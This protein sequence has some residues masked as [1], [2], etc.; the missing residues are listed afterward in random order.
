MTEQS[1]PQQ[2]VEQLLRKAQNLM[3]L[4][5]LPHI[6][7][8]YLCLPWY[9]KR[10]LN[11]REET[12][13][14]FEFALFEYGYGMAFQVLARH[15]IQTDAGPD[16]WQC[17]ARAAA[18]IDLDERQA[19]L[20]RRGLKQPMPEPPNRSFPKLDFEQLLRL[21][22]KEMHLP[23]VPYPDERPLE[24]FYPKNSPAAIVWKFEDYWQSPAISGAWHVLADYT[25][26]IHAS[27]FCWE[28]L[29][30]AAK[31]LTLTDEHAEMLR[32]GLVGVDTPQ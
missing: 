4:S 11:R 7:Y 22:M 23:E 8:V 15:A 5:D 14:H 27:H 30:E 2:T 3:G 9:R 29:A 28:L 26:K 32:R 12:V 16:V 19:E 13:V 31:F 17:L 1:E 18:A 6:A 20:L 25:T 21:A 24:D 10:R